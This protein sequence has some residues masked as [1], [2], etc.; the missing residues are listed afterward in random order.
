MF[1]E[2]INKLCKADGITPTKLERILKFGNGTIHNWDKCSP[3]LEKALLVAEYFGVGID[4]LASAN[5]PSKESRELAAR[6]ENYSTD[7][8]NLIR[9][10][11]SL[12]EKGERNKMSDDLVYEEGA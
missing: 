12:I 6:F 11:M 9:C 7:Q 3:S 1:F 2:Q 4:D 5:I 10:Y 8:K